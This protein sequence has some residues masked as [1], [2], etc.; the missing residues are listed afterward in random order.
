MRPVSHHHRDPSMKSD[1]EI[2]ERAIRFLT[3]HQILQPDLAQVAGEVGMSPHHFQRVFSRWAGVSPKRMLQYLTALEAGE[4]LRRRVPVLETSLSVGLSSGSRLHELFITLHG[5]SPAAYREQAHRL[6]IEWGTAMSPFGQ[7]LVALTEHGICWL[8]FH[9]DDDIGAGIAGMRGEWA[10]GA[11]SR[12]DARVAALMP[13]LFQ[14]AARHEPIH[15]MVRGSNFQL[16]VWRALLSIPAGCTTTYGD[17]SRAIGRPR[18][19]RAVGAAVGSNRVAWL[20]PC[21]RVI[22]ATGIIGGYRWGPHRKSMMLI[23]ESGDGD[24]AGGEVSRLP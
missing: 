9:D 17:I 10:H 23:K 13:R 8:S 3:D 24:S 12:N 19:D 16:Q 14:G 4:L 11:W 1:F 7:A 20:I 6:R 2:V 22:R 5:M 15:V 18:A 21:H